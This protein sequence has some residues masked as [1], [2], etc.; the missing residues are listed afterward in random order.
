MKALFSINHPGHVHFF[1][2]AI[3]LCQEKNIEVIIIARDKDITLTLLDQYNIPY[4]IGSK[5]STGILYNVI[6]IIKYQI[7]IFKLIKK[8]KPDVLLLDWYLLGQHPAEVIQSIR[9]ASPS[10]IIIVMSGDPEVKSS[11]RSIGI[12]N[13][14]S[15]IDPPGHLITAIQNCEQLVVQE[16]QLFSPNKINTL[17]E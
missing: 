4:I 3:L 1:H 6:E 9:L 13:F 7:K 8:H 5:Q 16:P 10:L 17:L 14:I 11:A 2:N 15:K 12:E